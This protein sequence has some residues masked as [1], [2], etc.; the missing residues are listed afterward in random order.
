MPHRNNTIV[1]IRGF[2][3]LLVVLQH[4]I[5]GCV[6]EYSDSLLFQIS[7]TLQLP[8]FIIIS[9]YVTRYSKPL[10]DGKSLWSFVKKRSLATCAH[11]L[12][13]RFL[14]EDSFSVKALSLISSTCCGIWTPDIGSLPPSG[15][16]Q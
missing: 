7:W 13:G 1:I 16:Y 8:L 15:S 9:G 2:A 3:M 6:T 5:S 12:R 11:G 14:S 10:T 4:T